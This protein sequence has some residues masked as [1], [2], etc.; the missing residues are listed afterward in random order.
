MCVV[1]GWGRITEKGPLSSVLQEV[2]LNL[3]EQSKCKHVLQTLRP[4]QKIFTVLCAGP[5]NGGRDACQGDSGGPLLCPRADGC[6]VAVGVTSWGKGCGRSW[7]NNKIKPLSRR[8]SPGVFTDVLLFLSWIKSNLRKD[9]SLC[10]VPDGVVPGSEG[11]IKNPGL[12]GQ[13]YNNNEMCLWSLRVAAGEHIL[14]EFL[15]FDL[16]NDTQCYSDQLTVYVDEDRRIGRFCGGHPPPPVLI[17]GSH[18]LTVQFV[19]DVSST[20]AGFAIKFSGVDKDYSF[21]AECGTVVL[22]QPKGAVW[23]PA[24]PQAY[25]NNTLCRWVI[26]APEGH[27]VKLDFDDFDLE[28]SEN[29]KYDSLTVFG[30]I[31][32]KDEIVVVCGASIPPAVLSYGGI[33]L[34]HF[35]T[36]N[37]ISARGFNTSFSFIREKDLRETAFEDQEEEAAD[38]NRV[39]SPRLLA[40]PYGMPDIFATSGLDAP[41][42]TE[43]DGKLLWHVS[44][45]LGAGYECSGAIIQL[46]W[47]LTDA[48]CVY[49]LEERYLRLLS[50]TAGGSKKQIRDVIGVLVHPHYSPLS[51]DSNVALL[52]LSSPLNLSESTQPVSLPSAGQETP[53]SLHCWAP[54][55]TSQISGHGQYRPVRLKISVLER[56]VC[57]QCH[58]TRLTPNILCAGLSSG[59][60]CMTHWPA[61]PLVC[62]T[63][64]SGVVLMGVKDR[65]EPC[66]GIQK[67]AVYSSVP[68]IM[69]WISQHLDME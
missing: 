36:D 48:H 44:I 51:L 68:A 15:E 24:Y 5:E 17:G 56:A 32:G 34:L 47:I 18:S 21:G 2:Q 42:T 55:W 43:D 25:R 49:N 11:I 50:V 66:G 64:T 59:A 19:S 45:S 27:I 60:S 62:L 14:L 3:L 26:Y 28:E 23:S 46:Q 63:N 35:S 57:E 6:W 53:P 16:E 10:G 7:N 20:G 61:G 29:C 9:R 4:G 39:I 67:C 52:K 13:S 37:T 58:R 65:G 31:D 8:G 33:M 12:P 38:D 1:G 22:L 54:A 69:H 30:D 40:A 41:R